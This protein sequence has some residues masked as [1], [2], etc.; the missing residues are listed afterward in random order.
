V[1]EL[2]I[3]IRKTLRAVDACRAS[4]ITIQKVSTLDHEVFNHTMKSAV[5]VSLRPA[6]VILRL[7]GAELPK[8]LCC[9][10][11]N[12]REELH[13]DPAEWLSTERDIEEDYRILLC[14]HLVVQ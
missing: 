8:I 6:K 11:D 14:C 1:A 3:L 5:L 9:L 7:S 13:F 2:E 4:P 12:I 10:W